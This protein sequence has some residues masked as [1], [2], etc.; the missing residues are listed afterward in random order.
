[1]ITNNEL[2]DWIRTGENEKV[3][4]VLEETPSLVEGKTD[5]GVSFLMYAVYCRNDKA[6]DL[7]KHKKQKLEFHE[8]V[9]L[10]DHSIVKEYISQQ[11]DLIN[12]YSSDGFTP[13]GLACFFGHLQLADWLIK[14]GA[15]VNTPS[16]N[17]LKVAPIHSACAISDFDLTSLLIRNGAS[18]NVRQVSGVTPL[19]SAAHN[20]QTKLARLLLVNG[21]EVNAKTDDGKTPLSLAEEKSFYQTAD[22]IKSFDG[23]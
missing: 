1:M 17:T 2:C 19:H 20:G 22:L 10:G 4:A 16:N 12:A 11:P 8:A 23:K 9:G 3:E 7:F 21:A 15:D 14:K 5:E 6:I 18:V 13:L